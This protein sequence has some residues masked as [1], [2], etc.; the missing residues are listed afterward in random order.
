M[1]PWRARQP[2]DAHFGSYRFT[3]GEFRQAL[4]YVNT[5]GANTLFPDCR[6][7]RAFFALRGRRSDFSAAIWVAICQFAQIAADY[8]RVCSSH[9]LNHH[10][11]FLG[12]I[13]YR[14]GQ[15]PR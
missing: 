9:C 8:F 4:C 7:I 14:L 2:P 5:L 12:I 10:S 6:D 15:K 11:N 13:T 1:R 3:I